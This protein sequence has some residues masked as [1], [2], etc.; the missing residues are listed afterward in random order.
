[1]VSYRTVTAEFF[2]SRSMD[3]VNSLSCRMKLFSRPDYMVKYIGKWDILSLT[4]LVFIERKDSI[5]A[6]Y[7]A[8][9]FLH[10]YGG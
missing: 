2:M 10:I 6:S 4:P 3:H 1:M 8:L 5:L 9:Y 7:N